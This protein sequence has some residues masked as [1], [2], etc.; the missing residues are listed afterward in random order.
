VPVPLDQLLLVLG[1]S[2]LVHRA[3]RTRRRPEIRRWLE[4]VTG[5]VLIGLGLRVALERR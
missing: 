5:I 2:I 3:Q 4:R 1:G